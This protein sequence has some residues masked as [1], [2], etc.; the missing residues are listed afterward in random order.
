MQMSSRKLPS[1]VHV[2]NDKPSLLSA[3]VKPVF[4]GSLAMFAI[5]AAALAYVF[6]QNRSNIKFG[7]VLNNLTVPVW[8][9]SAAGE[10]ILTNNAADALPAEPDGD[11]LDLKEVR[12]SEKSCEK[13]TAAGDEEYYLSI[14]PVRINSHIHYYL[15]SAVDVTERN[16]LTRDQQ[17]I[18]YQLEHLFKSQDI[19]ADLGKTLEEIN[20][21]FRAAFSSIIK[22]VRTEEETYCIYHKLE[23]SASEGDL[24]NPDGDKF[25]CGKNEPWLDMLEHNQSIFLDNLSENAGQQEI[26]GCF[27]P[28][29]LSRNIASLMAAP[30]FINEELYGAFC[31]FADHESHGSSISAQEREMFID[32]SRLISL[33]LS[34]RAAA[35]A[36][37]KANEAAQES[38]RAKSAFLSSISHE[39]RTPLNAVIGM[40]EI[41]KRSDESMEKEQQREFM[42][43]IVSAGNTLLSL[44][45]DVL[46]FS[47]LESS[48]MN[49]N[50]EPVDVGVLCSEL[51][52]MFQVTL[53]GKDVKVL[54]EIQKMPV[55]KLDILRMRQILINL[56]G[57]SAKFTE[58]GHIAL[59]AEF[60]ADDSSASGTLTVKVS[61]TGCGIPAD[62]LSYV[63]EPFRQVASC[64]AGRRG[65]ILGTGL[66]LAIC[67]QLTELMGGTVD[68][69]STVGSGTVFTV[70]IPH[71][72]IIKDSK[73][74]NCSSCDDDFEE[75]EYDAVRELRVLI[76]DDVMLNRKVL[77]AICGKIGCKTVKGA[78]SAAEALELMEKERF[79]WVLTDLWMPEVD[80]CG[81]AACIRK[82]PKFAGIKICVVTADTEFNKGADGLFDAMAVKPLT[83]N[84]VLKIFKEDS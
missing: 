42:Q 15:K 35:V 19:E 3:Y 65:S 10:L 30:V 51:A 27:M 25:I 60:S 16:R 36:L 56:L 69:E 37:D 31:V 46:D 4:Y 9:Y 41:L 54:A 32:I 52:K 6:I 18:N 24:L 45:N 66:G 62:K 50:L 71:A 43:T 63:F 75:P 78:E 81:L 14:R 39:L 21:H 47:K 5:A 73:A 17:F 79:D 22:L 40:A 7:A 83:F 57:N 76:V 20:L 44:I 8:L 48:R 34:R 72:D 67:R 23:S 64:P 29:L 28:A 33:A 1:W 77:S 80:G 13:D 55:L 2:V 70:R 68:V 82:N 58:H 61:D 12:Q 11:G 26:C 38:L 74:V 84:G 49:L 53:R 59:L